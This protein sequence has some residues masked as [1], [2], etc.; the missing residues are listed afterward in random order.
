MA[1]AVGPFTD[2]LRR[3]G[4]PDLPPLTTPFDPGVAPVVLENHLV[5][6]GHLMKSL[7][8]SMSCWMIAD[9]AAT[10]RK[11]DAA[12]SFDVPAVAGGGPYEIAL[13]QNQ[14]AAYLELCAGVGFSGI[15]CAEGFTRPTVSPAEIVSLAAKHG[16]RVQFELGSKHDGA[17]DR[18]VVRRLIDQGKRWLDAGAGQLVV[19]ARESAV[20][21]GVFD[22]GGHLN[23]ELA[24]RLA[25]EFGL[26]TLVFEAP[27]KRSQFALLDHFGQQIQ[28]GNVRLDELLRVEIY[29][30]G[31]HSDSFSNERLRPSTPSAEPVGS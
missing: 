27:D 18:A 12:R 17:F 15:E 8:I 31:L 5:Q 10:Q 6:S 9:Q 24:E 30:R 23:A 4:V 28:L 22:S 7:K 2:Y 11:L 21:I 19:E 14:F 20:E 29:R 25:D 26:S 13:A 3:I 1:E 16:L